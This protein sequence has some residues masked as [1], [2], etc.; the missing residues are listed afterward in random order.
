MGRKFWIFIALLAVLMLALE[1]QM[2]RHFTW[3]ATFAHADRQPFGCYVF[4]SMMAT[5]MPH[6]YT[7]C[8]KTVSQLAVEKAP[9]RSIIILRFGYQGG[10]VNVDTLLALAERGNRI[11]FAHSYFGGK[12]CDTLS[13]SCNTFVNSFLN[14]VL[15]LDTQRRD[16]IF[17]TD[18]SLHYGAAEYTVYSQMVS[19]C[20]LDSLP[21][22][23]LAKIHN[24]EGIQFAKDHIDKD[25]PL[26]KDDPLKL[27]VADIVARSYPV[28][29]GE[30]ILV[31][32]PLLMTNYGILN[33]PAYV[34]RLMNRLKD[35]PVVRT[36]AYMPSYDVAEES[37][38]RELL[39]RPPLRWALYLTLMGI[40]LLMVFT[41]RRRQRAIP[42]VEPPKNYQLDL[43]RRIGTL[44]Y[45]RTK[46]NRIWKKT[47]N[48][49]NP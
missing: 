47:T 27:R 12:L 37:P 39:K 20:L 14:E 42:V 3:K 18:D 41:A 46:H 35:L 48:S 17:W 25:S 32:T 30:I 40:V 34:H 8:R 6:G 10:D 23:P 7:V 21:S 49:D 13:M 15:K 38:F 44:L 9:P 33:N 24:W 22:V 31:T 1:Y 45:Q 4:D 36:E 16:T 19:S 2:P 26:M 43:I 11:L 28:G 5:T 29:K